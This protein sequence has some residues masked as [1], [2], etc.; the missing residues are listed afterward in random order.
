[1]TLSQW[2]EFDSLRS[3]HKTLWQER[4]PRGLTTRIN[5]FKARYDIARRLSSMGFSP[6][7]ED[8]TA[9]AYL[10]GTRL[11]LAYSAAEAFMRAEDLFR[12]RSKPA[13]VTTWSIS[14]KRLAS[15]LQPLVTLI[16]EQADNHGTLKKATKGYLQKF[17]EG[18]SADVRPVATAL[19]HVHAHGGLTARSLTG[20][21]DPEAAGRVKAIDE[22]VE[23]LLDKCD[24]KFS[25]LMKDLSA[26]L[27]AK[28]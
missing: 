16:L 25:G 20:A 23:A 27:F 5:I 6:D 18:G 24:E 11:L 10:A 15:D 19:R 26:R 8:D 1:M 7:Y 17:S 2:S 12:G 21:A 3:N 13:S 4:M 14:R 28:A 22:L 9:M